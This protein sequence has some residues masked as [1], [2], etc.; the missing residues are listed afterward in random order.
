MSA[1]DRARIA[2][3]LAD[4][5]LSYR[6][7]A[8]QE[9]CSDWTVRAVAREIAGDSRPMKSRRRKRGGG[10]DHAPPALVGWTI[11]AGLAAAVVG[12]FWLA[13]RGAPPDGGPM[14]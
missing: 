8:R 9:N 12:A 3:L 14:T 6:D 7:I 2:E 11:L 4:E 10:E 13:V 1:I 5:S